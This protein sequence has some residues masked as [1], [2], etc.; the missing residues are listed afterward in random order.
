VVGDLE[1]GSAGDVE[2]LGEFAM[3]IPAEAFCDVA[4]H[5][6]HGIAELIAKI[7]IVDRSPFGSKRMDLVA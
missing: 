4:G 6:A 5:R 1:K 2:K 3:A 7:P